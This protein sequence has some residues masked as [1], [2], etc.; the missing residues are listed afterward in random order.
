MNPTE[1]NT[2][3]ANLK[4]C[5]L[6]SGSNGNAYYIAAGNEAILVDCGIS[7]KQILGR[8]KSRGVDLRQVKAVFIT[9]EHSDHVR[10]M[11]VFCQNFKADCYM[12][13]G[14]ALKCKAFYMP[15]APV[16]AICYNESVTIGP[17]T[18]HCFEK[19]HDVEEPCSFRIEVDGVSIGV[20]TDIGC[21][22]EGLKDNLAKCHVAFLESNYDE[23]MLWAGKYP[24]YL[25]Q[26][27]ASDHGHLSN[28][29]AADIVREVNP[30]H[31][32][33]LILSHLSAD[34]NRPQIAEKAFAE[35][36]GKY[37]VMHASRYEAGEVFYVTETECSS[38][39]KPIVIPDRLD[40][41]EP[42]V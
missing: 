16:K 1:N 41:P 26:R 15:V 14:T 40:R 42:K 4:I 20:F 38:K 25:K 29:Q 35:F 31:L 8:A 22:C 21:S 12:T 18:V 36:A 11:R 5:S 28:V 30:P 9:H 6:A 17:F 10:G 7:Y 3:Q 39:P 23:A 24:E 19:P 27:V 33:T 37:K 13:K 34:N 32:H 2:T